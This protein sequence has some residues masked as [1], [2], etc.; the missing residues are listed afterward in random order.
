MPGQIQQELTRYGSKILGGL[1]SFKDAVLTRADGARQDVVKVANGLTKEVSDAA[2]VLRDSSE[3][4]A[5]WVAKQG[6]P[7]AKEGLRKAAGVV[8]AHAGITVR[9]FGA[10]LREMATSP[11]VLERSKQTT[12]DL[13]K[14]LVN[15]RVSM[16]VSMR[17]FLGSDAALIAG[18]DT[19]QQPPKGIPVYPQRE[20]IQHVTKEYLPVR[21]FISQT[22]LRSREYAQTPPEEACITKQQYAFV[23]ERPTTAEDLFELQ[24]TPE[25]VEA[26]IEVARASTAFAPFQAVK[27]QRGRGKKP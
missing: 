20:S 15:S 7:G 13:T 24:I 12:F 22:G 16:V 25:Q 5:E 8:A 9:R 1:V 10:E 14:L 2:T 21:V 6:I 19:T 11:E 23:A 4:G 26:A 17:N 27:T 18:F 3:R